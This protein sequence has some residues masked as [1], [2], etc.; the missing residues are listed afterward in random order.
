MKRLMAVL[1]CLALIGGITGAVIAGCGGDSK[2]KTII[3]Q[4][5][6]ALNQWQTLRFKGTRGGTQQAS[7]QDPAT[8]EYPLAGDAQQVGDYLNQHVAMD[9][10]QGII[11]EYY[12]IGNMTY[13][14]P[15]DGAWYYDDSGT[16]DTTSNIQGLRKQDLDEMLAAATD[17]KVTSEEGSVVTVSLTVGDS[18]LKQ[19]SQNLKDAAAQGKITQ[20]DLDS[21]LTT[22][23]NMKITLTIAFDTSN[24][25]WQHM[26]R[27]E[28]VSA[29][30]A[31]ASI[32]E[33]LDFYDYGADIQIVAPAATQNAQSWSAY[34][35]QL[36]DLTQQLQQQQQTAP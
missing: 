9:V 16:A 8:S 35:Q 14:N 12:M 13:I 4:A 29:Q 18:Y 21:W 19:I 1:L 3:T 31:T 25:T 36:S 34:L 23:N 15:G 6:D 5:R 22:L 2:A 26:D 28:E 11:A 27:K 10:G 20:E 30:G 33:S 17:A 32:Q 24:N 7:G